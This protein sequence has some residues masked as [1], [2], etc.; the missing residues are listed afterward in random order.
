MK[1]SRVRIARKT[2][3]LFYTK[4]KLRNNKS[5]NSQARADYWQL[6]IVILFNLLLE[7]KLFLFNIACNRVEAEI[8][9]YFYLLLHTII[10]DPISNMYNLFTQRNLPKHKIWV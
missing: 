6:I 7:L 5:L 3:Y 8:Q 1:L 4:V 2:E 9:N 10:Y